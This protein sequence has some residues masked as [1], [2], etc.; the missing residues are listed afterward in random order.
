[1]SQRFQVS[2]ADVLEALQMVY[3]PELGL[4]IVNLGLIYEVHIEDYTVHVVMTLTTPGCP[5]HDAIVVGAEWVLRQLP[6]VKRVEIE[7]TWNPPWDP[8]RMS[9]AARAALGFAW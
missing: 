3:D 2:E 5:M 8:S 6:D 9:Q 7:L 1:M 4:D